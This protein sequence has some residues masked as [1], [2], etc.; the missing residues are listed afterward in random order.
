ME[1]SGVVVPVLVAGTFSSPTFRPD[2]EK[3]LKQ[4]FTKGL[5]DVGTLKDSLKGQQDQGKEALKKKLEEGILGQ[6][7]VAPKPPKK[8]HLHKRNLK[9]PRK[10]QRNFSKVYHLVSD[11]RPRLGREAI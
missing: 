11:H 10:R 7:Q 3:M 9:P 1:R 8:D 4:E 2:L 5:P 6:K